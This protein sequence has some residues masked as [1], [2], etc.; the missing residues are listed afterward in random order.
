MKSIRTKITLCIV[1]CALVSSAIVGI[2]SLN[3]ARKLVLEQSEESLSLEAKGSSTELS[4]IISNIEQSVDTVSEICM[5][6]MDWEDFKSSNL[7]Q[8][9][10]T[11]A[12]KQTFLLF[13]K[14]TKGVTS[15][16][17]RY[18]PEFTDPKSGIYYIMGEGNKFTTG[19]LTDFSQYEPTDV[20]NVGWYYIP[21]N[22]GKPTWMDPYV[23]GNTGQHLVSY[24]VPLFA[25]D[26]ANIGIVGMDVQ[27]SQ[28]TDSVDAI[29][30]FDS[31]YGFLFKEDG[32]IQYHKEAEEGSSITDLGISAED[33]ALITDETNE[34]RVIDYNFSGKVYSLSAYKLPNGMYLAVTVPRAELTEAADVLTKKIISII[35]G[36]L[37]VCLILGIVVGNR[38]A[39]PITSITGIIKQSSTLDFS[40]SGSSGDKLKKKRDETGVMA[41]AVSEMRSSLRKIVSTIEAVEETILD[42]VGH[43]EEIMKENN[44]I[45]E[46][47]SATTEELAAETE[48]TSASTS[49]INTNV[50]MISEGANNIRNRTEQGRS[51]SVEVMNRAQALKEKTRVASDRTLSVYEE[52]KVRSE[53]AVEQSKAVEKINE[54]TESIKAISTQTNL[55]S[56]NANIEAARA[57]EAGRGFAVVATEIGAL[58]TQTFNTVEGIN[59]IVDEVNSAVDNI[60][61]CLTTVM[62]FLESTVISDYNSFTEVSEKY[63]ADAHGFE[64]AMTGI[65]MDIVELTNRIGEITNAIEQVNES[66]NQTAEGVSVIADKSGEAVS[67]TVEGYE[68]VKECRASLEKLHGIINQFKI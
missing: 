45:S 12:L 20:A 33:L 50:S 38:I 6:D 29:Q 30:V 14:N 10:Y 9:M 42:N 13:A 65:N 40:K 22:N 15:S 61:G 52:M 54:L 17:Y 44:S 59:A 5:D 47:N 32:T 11:G 49:L 62:E 3:N 43:L 27:Y 31:G 55:L 63:E 4:A 36:C 21:V 41:G 8:T 19:E 66:I 58:A 57:G 16:Y 2:V 23:N 56:L 48:E 34:G 46:D 28:L 18:N 25:E 64:Q 7:T 68:A 53:A 24:V 67:K 26:G 37:V 1:L 60:A 35:V 51:D 39:A